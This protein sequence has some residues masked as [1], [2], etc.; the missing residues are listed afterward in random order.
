[1]PF[2]DPFFS[3][4]GTQVEI[5]EYFGPGPSVYGL[6]LGLFPKLLSFLDVK[7]PT[8]CFLEKV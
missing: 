8:D 7:D 2:L 6:S 4:Y 3:L 1:M 5:K